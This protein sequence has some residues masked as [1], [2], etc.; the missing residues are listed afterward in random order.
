MLD[1]TVTA[2]IV[3]ATRRNNLPLPGMMD[4]GAYQDF[5]ETDAA[6]NPGNSAAR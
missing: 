3:S 1:H 5:I 6:I 4:E 2:G